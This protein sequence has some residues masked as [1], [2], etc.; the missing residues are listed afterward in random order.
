LNASSL[1]FSFFQQNE[2]ESIMRRRLIMIFLLCVIS[3]SAP[4]GIVSYFRDR[5]A[6]FLDIF[7]F[8]I[9]APRGA[10]G[11][12][13][14]ARATALAQVGAVYFEGEHFGID[15]RGIGVWEERR[16]Q[17]G[18]SLLS[19]S[20]VENEI[21]WGNYFLKQDTPWMRFQERGLIRNDVY[22]DDGRKHFFSVSAEIQPSILPGF[23]IGIY[24]VEILDFAV[25]LLTLDPQND[26]LARVRKYAP[27][28]EEEETT[29]TKELKELPMDF[30]TL[31]KSTL[32]LSHEQVEFHSMTNTTEPPV[33]P[34]KTITEV[35][36]KKPE[37]KK[38]E[39]SADSAKV[40]QPKFKTPPAPAEQ[41][42]S[43]PSK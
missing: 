38:T 29:S 16:K 3:V 8:R 6:D 27:E 21:V 1:C 35:Q 10:R 24:P 32:P 37:E 17:G 7:L 12:G 11:I 40:I 22:W 36:G 4:A 31:K 15:R 14:R 39:A 26:D 20:S 13:F 5:G 2:K 42:M 25:G 9:S 19:F 28:Y 30:E 18:I 43:P 34:L 41:S 33:E 23:E